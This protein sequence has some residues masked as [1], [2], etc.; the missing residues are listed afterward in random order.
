[1]PLQGH[2]GKPQQGAGGRGRKQGQEPLLW[3]L[4]ER[5][6][7]SGEQTLDRLVEIVSVGSGLEGWSPV[8]RYLALG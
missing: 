7:R 6:G 5:Q 1:M 2:P 4:C 8:V 3:C